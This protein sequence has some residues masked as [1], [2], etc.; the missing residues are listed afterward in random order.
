MYRLM[1]KGFHGGGLRYTCIKESNDLK[2]ISD[3][4]K[5]LVTDD[6]PLRDLIVVQDV[7]FEFKCAIK[8]GSEE[9]KE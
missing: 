5:S 1:R 4:M 8:W 9:E 6:I 2:T 7:E 3:C